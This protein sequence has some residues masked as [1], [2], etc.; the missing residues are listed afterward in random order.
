[1]ILGT[2]CWQKKKIRQVQMMKIKRVVCDDNNVFFSRIYKMTHNKQKRTKGDFTFCFCLFVNDIG[3]IL[4]GSYVFRIIFLENLW[5]SY[6]AQTLELHIPYWTFWAWFKRKRTL[7][8][9][10]IYRCRWLRF[11]T[12]LRDL[13][14]WFYG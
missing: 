12:I 8:V 9:T 13:Y 4:C 5:A 7:A 6:W 2:F 10:K 14:D 3:L 1:M 11:L